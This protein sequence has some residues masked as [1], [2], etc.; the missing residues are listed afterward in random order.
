MAPLYNGDLVITNNIGKSKICG[1]EPRYNEQILT[2]P[3]HNLP[4]YNECFALDVARPN[5]KEGLDKNED[6]ENEDWSIMER[7]K[8]THPRL[9]PQYDSC[10]T[11]L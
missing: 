5:K 7:E 8:V 1:N 3:T 9:M 2:V 11:S 10:A 4:R 6:S